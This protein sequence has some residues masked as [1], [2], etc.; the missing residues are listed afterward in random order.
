MKRIAALAAILLLSIMTGCASKTLNPVETDQVEMPRSY[1]YD[2]PQIIVPPGTTVT[3]H[4]GDN[5]SHTVTFDQDVAQE[6][7]MEPGESGFTLFDRPGEYTYYCTFHAQQMKG[8]VIVR[9]R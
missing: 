1:R 5:F 7:V 6:L 4:N 3:W 9:A 8:K 2:P